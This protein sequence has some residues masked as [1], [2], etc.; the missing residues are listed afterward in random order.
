[1]SLL[2]HGLKKIPGE[3]MIANIAGVEKQFVG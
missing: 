1:M 3:E 2:A